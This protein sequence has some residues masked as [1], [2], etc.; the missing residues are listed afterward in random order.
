MPSFTKA[1]MSSQ[2][3]DELTGNIL[4]FWM[5]HPVDRVSGG[6]HGAI[7]NDLQV[8]EDVPRASILCARILWTFSAAYRKFGNK[9]YLSMAEYAY[10]YLHTPPP[11]LTKNR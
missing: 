10:Q 6:F 7:S 8:H 4:P 2:F 9:A 11:L 5:N 1:N 3:K